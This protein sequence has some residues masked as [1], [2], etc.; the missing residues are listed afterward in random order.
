M[1]L[2]SLSDDEKGYVRTLAVLTVIA[3]L[4]PSL[5]RELASGELTDQ[6]VVQAFF[7]RHGLEGLRHT[8]TGTTIEAVIIATKLD[9][10]NF[11]HPPM[12]DLSARSPLWHRY[13]EIVDSNKPTDR[14]TQATWSHAHDVFQAVLQFLDSRYRGNELLGFQQSVERLE[15]LSPDLLGVEGDQ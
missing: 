10:R 13:E 9:W 1:V 11:P 8:P 5:Y 12:D 15:L 3:T 14:A 6:E 7:G 4:D 2:S